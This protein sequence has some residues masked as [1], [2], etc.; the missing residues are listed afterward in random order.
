MKRRAMK[1]DRLDKSTMLLLHF[2]GDVVDA[3]GHYKPTTSD[4]N[5]GA[6]KFGE[7]KYK[8]YIDI[9]DAAELLKLPNFTVDFWIK[10]DAY[11]D[12]GYGN[13][14]AHPI[15]VNGNHIW[16]NS[17]FGISGTNMT[18]FPAGTILIEVETCLYSGNNVVS[19]SGSVIKLNTWHHIC[20]TK[21][22]NAITIFV[23]GKV[24]LQIKNYI[25]NSASL[26]KMTLIRIMKAYELTYQTYG[27]IDEFRISN[28]ARWTSNFQVPTKPY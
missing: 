8:G 15:C 26:N 21:N 4:M 1:D 7:A 24:V 17:L 9:P 16:K 28:I 22:T 5:F 18:G 23:D 11:N 3:S 14:T 12:N 27:Y 25:Q 10:I 19:S 13:Q 6:G 20:Y 2:D